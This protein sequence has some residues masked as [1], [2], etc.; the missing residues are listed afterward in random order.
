MELLERARV[1]FSADRF[2][3]EVTGITIEAVAENYAKC[4][5]VIEDK[6]MNAAHAVMGGAIF[7]LADFA[8][9]VAS[10]SMGRLT[11]SMTSQITYLNT[12][13]GRVLIAETNCEK[14]GKRTSS[15]TIHITDE[16]G[17]KVAQVAITGMH[18]N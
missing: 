5:L 13:K 4:Q 16:L 15:Y 7:T 17:T 18:L 11:V 14:A 3:T 8:F 2:A 12:A 9:A 1:Q 6:H 10:N